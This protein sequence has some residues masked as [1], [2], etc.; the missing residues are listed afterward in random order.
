MEGSWGR[1]NRMNPW[2]PSWQRTLLQIMWG[3]FSY[4]WTLDPA[5]LSFL[6]WFWKTSPSHLLSSSRV[7]VHLC[8]PVLLPEGH[9][10]PLYSH[11]LLLIGGALCKVRMTKST[12]TRGY[13]RE[14]LP[15]G[16]SNNL[17]VT[18]DTDA[19]PRTAPLGSCLPSN[20]VPGTPSLAESP[21]GDT[22]LPGSAVLR[23][24]WR[25]PCLSQT[26]F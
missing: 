22:P 23:S 2:C 5:T 24:A 25:C 18:K 26:V 16:V 3:S 12:R 9:S 6:L 15:A 10:A 11:Y 20:M 7:K 8:P 4:L 19:L 17:D 13:P 14:I 1:S 21:A